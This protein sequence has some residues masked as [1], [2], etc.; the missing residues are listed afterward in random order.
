[1]DASSKR[2]TALD[3]H[4]GLSFVLFITSVFWL[5]IFPDLCWIYFSVYFVTRQDW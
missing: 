1:M 2:D 4:T 3:F 5:F